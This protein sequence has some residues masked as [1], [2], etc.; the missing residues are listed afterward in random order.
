MNLVEGG[1]GFPGW[2]QA[3]GCLDPPPPGWGQIILSY[4]GWDPAWT[5]L[6]L[7]LEEWGGG[8]W[9]VSARIPTLLQ[10]WYRHRSNET[11]TFSEASGDVVQDELLL[12]IVKPSP[13]RRG[14][15]HGKKCG[16]HPKTNQA[17]LQNAPPQKNL[18]KDQAKKW[19]SW[20]CKILFVQ[21]WKIKTSRDEKLLE[22]PKVEI[23]QIQQIQHPWKACKGPKQ[24]NL[25]VLGK[26]GN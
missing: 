1:K 6:A 7:R 16:T 10:S 23:Q 20:R 25:F 4:A 15:G 21:H 5:W 8:A 13:N 9:H 14:Q 3:V 11:A 19:S 22:L 24:W 17:S 2:K 12:R 18:L 26:K